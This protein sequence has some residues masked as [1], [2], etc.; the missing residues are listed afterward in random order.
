MVT[1]RPNCIASGG[2]IHC[3]ISDH[4]VVFAVRTMRISGS[5]GIS[6]RATV[7]KFKNFD[8][9]VFRSELSKINF[10]HIKTLTSDPNEMWLLWKSFLLDV[11]NQ[12]APIDNIKIKGNNL[13][14]ITAEVRQLA[15]ERDFLRKKANKTGSKY[16][17]QAFQQIKHR[18]TYKLRSLRSEYYS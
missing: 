1:N 10:D 6:K 5:K 14:Y 9:P 4:D 7:P 11:V 2:V 16:L 13:P 12:H 8:L 17:R 3:G 18:V 15:R